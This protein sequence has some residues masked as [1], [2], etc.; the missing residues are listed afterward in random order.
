[1]GEEK[2]INMKQLVICFRIGQKEKKNSKQK[3][4]NAILNM[5]YKNFKFAC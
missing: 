3:E 5:T 4:D 1:M 2:S